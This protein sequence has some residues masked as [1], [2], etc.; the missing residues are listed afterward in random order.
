VIVIRNIQLLDQNTINKIAAGEVVERPMAVVKELVENSIDAGSTAITI[1]IKDG[2][3]QLIRVTDNGS[4]ISNDDI[5]LAF[6]RHSTSKIKTIDDL[7][8]I[9]SLGFRGEALSSISAV[10]QVELIT[11]TKDALT[12]I[13][14]LIEGGHEKYMEEIGC[15]SGTTFVVRNLFYNT[16]ARRKFLKS[17]TTEAGYISEIIERLALAHPEISFKYINGGQVK[18]QTSGNGNRKDIVYHVFGKEIASNMIEIISEKENAKLSGFIGL[19]VISRGNRSYMNYFINGRYI[20]S[21]VIQ[22][23][24]ESAYKNYTM[25]HRYPFVCLNYEINMDEMDVNVHPTKMD[26]RFSNQEEIFHLTYETIHRFLREKELIP[27]ISLV[28]EEEKQ[29][30][31]T[32]SSPEPFEA[33]RRNELLNKTLNQ[34]SFKPD[35]AKQDSITIPIRYEKPAKDDTIKNET[36]DHLREQPSYEYQNGN[37]NYT[38]SNLFEEKF[39]E[40]KQGQEYRIIGQL[41]ATYWL[42][43]YNQS[44]FMIDQHAAHEKVLYESII[45]NLK[46]KQIHSQLLCPALLMSLNQKEEQVLLSN[47]ELLEQLGFQIEHFGGKDYNITAVPSDFFSL[48]AKDILIELLDL[49]VEDK[50]VSFDMVLER[51]ASLA[52]KAAVKANHSM[53]VVELKEL[54]YQLMGLENPYHCP[55]GR[56]TMI[57]M[58]KS[59]IEKKFKRII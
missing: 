34:D 32:P 49:L 41:F 15:P 16:P 51:C 27:N 13:R 50:R 46:E 24:I 44:L 37:Q 17:A 39:L 1:E 22:S 9:R 4:G 5:S 55:H 11:K 28:K 54:I 53:S 18:L 56:P 31:V 2:G 38:Q 47:M 29:K 42:V 48:P 6:H 45:H 35:T 20:K 19:P 21:Q 59:E 26:V 30:V 40:P 25:K 43:E 3:I 14:F 58:A 23:A 7:S 36:Y 57:K 12:G 33:V 52:C 10:S 8:S